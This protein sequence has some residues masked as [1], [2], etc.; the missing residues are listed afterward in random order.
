MN[1]KE[2]L[3]GLE[4]H[5]HA[6]LDA[7]EHIKLLEMALTEAE[8]TIVD[9]KAENSWMSKKLEELEMYAP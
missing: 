8:K 9:L 7:A 6:A 4:Q 1:T 5:A 3:V 2:I